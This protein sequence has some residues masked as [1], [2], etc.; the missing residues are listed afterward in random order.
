MIMQVV[1]SLLSD[2]VHLDDAGLK[3][4]K[5]LNVAFPLTEVIL[6]TRLGCK[7]L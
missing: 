2:A 1:A 3:K 4:K 5:C 7:Y 6:T